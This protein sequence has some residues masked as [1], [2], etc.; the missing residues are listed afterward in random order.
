[1]K[2]KCLK[3]KER[4]EEISQKYMKRNFLEKSAKIEKKKGIKSEN[5]NE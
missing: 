3:N 5:K 2:K 4:R 1:M